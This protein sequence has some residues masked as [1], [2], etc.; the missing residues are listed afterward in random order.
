MEKELED[1]QTRLGE[2]VVKTVEH[3]ATSKQDVKTGT[4]GA[5]ALE[6][7]SNSLG[8]VTNVTVLS[9]VE[10]GFNDLSGKPTTATEV[11]TAM[12]NIL[13]VRGMM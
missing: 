8:K 2:S 7:M 4:Q 5:R 6:V 9:N 3:V 13:S 12:G 11:K 10:K 1:A